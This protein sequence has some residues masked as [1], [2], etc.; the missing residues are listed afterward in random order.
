M[1]FSSYFS[2]I[3][4]LSSETCDDTGKYTRS[5]EN[6][7]HHYDV[8]ANSPG[9]LQGSIVAGFCGGS[10]SVARGFV[11]QKA[12]LNSRSTGDP[13]FCDNQSV[14]FDSKDS[15]STECNG[16]ELRM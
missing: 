5:M 4:L 8:F 12:Y 14:V 13:S 10:A 11:T 16:T 7:A 2:N 9:E 3:F 6:M 15:P 1:F